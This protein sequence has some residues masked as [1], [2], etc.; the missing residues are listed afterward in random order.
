[1]KIISAYCLLNYSN[2][3]RTKLNKVRW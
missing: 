3:K 2:F 1:M